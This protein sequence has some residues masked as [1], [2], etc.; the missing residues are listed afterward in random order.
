MTAEPPSQVLSAFDRER[1]AAAGLPGGIA[2]A[3]T[4]VSDADPDIHGSPT[5]LQ[6][7]M[8]DRTA[9]LMFR[10]GDVIAHGL[11]ILTRRSEGARA[12]QLKPGLDLATVNADGTVGQ[13]RHAHANGTRN[14]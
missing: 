12:A 13:H 11:G 14:A 3:G 8:P 9:V 7:A 2:A 10:P 6:A 4:R 5:T 1:L